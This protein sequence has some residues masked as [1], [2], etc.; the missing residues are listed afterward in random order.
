M[1]KNNKVQL[2]V[3]IAY[4]LVLLYFS[5]SNFKLE[6]SEDKVP[7]LDKVLHLLAYVILAVFW[8]FYFLNSGIKKALKT[9]L[10]A[11]LVFGILLES[12]QEWINPLRMFDLLDLLAN[13]IGVVIGTIIVHYLSKSKVKLI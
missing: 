2:A 5:L 7:H 8:C 11:T 13:C 1:L 12:V 10:T 6:P 9:S 3:A 4:T